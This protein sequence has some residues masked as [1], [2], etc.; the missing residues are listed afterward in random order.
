MITCSICR[1]Q[2]NHLASIC[3]KCGG[4]LQTKVENINLF[5][6]LWKLIEHPSKAFKN[7]AMAKHKNYILLL[8]FIL[9][10]DFSFL[11][12]SYWNTYDRLEDTKIFLPVG[13]GGGILFGLILI[14]IISLLVLLFAKIFKLKTRFR[15]IWSVISFSFVPLIYSFIFLM[16]VKLVA[17]G[18]SY[19]SANLSPQTI[20]Q[21]VYYLLLIID[22]SLFLWTAI[23]F[24]IAIKTIFDLNITK[25]LT[26]CFPILIIVSV[27]FYFSKFLIYG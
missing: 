23:L 27:A 19:F 21:F 8:A 9:G 5:E 10:I 11:L 18:I 24:L 17:F 1:T 7:I 22:G 12:L 25:A 13:I 20:N 3:G 16:P 14:T 26:I 6:T 15:D 2:N 4:Y